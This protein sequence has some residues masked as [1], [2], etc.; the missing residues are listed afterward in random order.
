MNEQ[1]RKD[2]STAQDYVEEH[3]KKVREILAVLKVFQ[4]PRW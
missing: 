2:F 1:V 4:M 3:Y